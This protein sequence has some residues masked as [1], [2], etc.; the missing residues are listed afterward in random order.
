LL[1]RHHKARSAYEQP[2]LKLGEKIE[3]F[4]ISR[5]LCMQKSKIP[6]PTLMIHKICTTKLEFLLKICWNRTWN[7]TWNWTWN[8]TCESDVKNRTSHVRSHVRFLEFFFNSKHPYALWLKASGA[9]RLSK[10]ACRAPRGVQKLAGWVGSFLM[11]YRNNAG[12]LG[13]GFIS[14]CLETRWL[15]QKCGFYVPEPPYETEF[16]KKNCQKKFGESKTFSGSKFDRDPGR[17]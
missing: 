13:A 6:I 15:G 11:V 7:R 9:R 16:G 14:V 12:R 8:R 17:C 2:Q 5:R 1:S 4:E 10:S 3:S